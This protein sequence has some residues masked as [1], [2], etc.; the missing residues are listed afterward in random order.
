[1]EEDLFLHGEDLR[2]RVRLF[3]HV[4]EVFHCRRVDFFVLGG[5][6]ERCDSQQLRFFLVHI[7]NGEVAIDQ[8]YSDKEGLGEAFELESNADEPVNQDGPGILSDVPLL[9]HVEP[10]WLRG[11]L[12]LLHVLLDVSAVDAHMVNVT[13]SG[14]VDFRDVLVDVILN[15]LVVEI[16]LRGEADLREFVPRS[17]T[18]C[19]PFVRR[20][21]TLQVVLVELERI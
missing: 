14:F 20:A 13:E 12:R 21:N 2:A 9:A 5:N 11:T 15:A 8:V 10:V 3:A 16:L 18:G 7:E 19:G 17:E 6:E 1:M 4:D